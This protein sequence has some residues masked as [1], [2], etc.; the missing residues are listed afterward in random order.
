MRKPILRTL[1]CL[2]LGNIYCEAQAQRQE[3][4]IKFAKGR[5]WAKITSQIKG[6]QLAY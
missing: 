2:L 5:S 3:K 4:Q 1:V 6:E